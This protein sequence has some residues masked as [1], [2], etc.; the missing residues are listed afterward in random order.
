MTAGAAHV[1]VADYRNFCRDRG[2]DPREPGSLYDFFVDPAC[3]LVPTTARV[4]EFP[5]FR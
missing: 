2:L 3:R 4:E 5:K 1:T